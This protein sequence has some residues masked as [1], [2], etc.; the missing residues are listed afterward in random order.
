MQLKF[1]H[2]LFYNWNKR[3][4]MVLVEKRC[5]SAIKFQRSTASPKI[6]LLHE[7]SGELFQQY[8][9][10]SWPQRCI[11]P[12]ALVNNTQFGFKVFPRKQSFVIALPSTYVF[13]LPVKPQFFSVGCFSAVHSAITVVNKHHSRRHPFGYGSKRMFLE[14]VSC[15]RKTSCSLLSALSWKS[16]DRTPHTTFK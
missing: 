4:R 5:S 15:L 8:S 12:S 3:L 1:L 7:L 11:A 13:L 16:I 10:R 6:P 14:G 2:I 9:S